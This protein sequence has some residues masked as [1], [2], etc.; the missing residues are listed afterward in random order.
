MK[1]EPDDYDEFAEFD[2]TL[3]EAE[4]MWAEGT[5]VELIDP[6]TKSTR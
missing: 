6:P 3:E 1:K 5:P 2:I 4:A